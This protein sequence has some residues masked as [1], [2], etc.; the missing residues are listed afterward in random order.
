MQSR[1]RRTMYPQS[2]QDA[3]RR[4]VVSLGAWPHPHGHFVPARGLRLA[5]MTVD[6]DDLVAGDGIGRS[7]D[8]REPST[9]PA[10]GFDRDDCA[11][12]RERGEVAWL[13]V[14]CGAAHPVADDG[15]SVAE[16]HLRVR[17]CVRHYGDLRGVSRA[18]IRC[19]G[20]RAHLLDGTGPRADLRAHARQCYLAGVARRSDRDAR[21]PLRSVQERRERGQVVERDRVRL[22]AARAA[23]DVGAV[24][25]V[26][27]GELVA[28]AAHEARDPVG[29]RGRG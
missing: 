24:I 11:V 4:R 18:R 29:T 27:V 9:L 16:R 13:D 5:G 8:A 19:H 14:A 1:E 2:G 3:L 23:H 17:L 7:V 25:V 6:R 26:C 21:G 15:P 12:S 28:V 10:R 22:A 20:C